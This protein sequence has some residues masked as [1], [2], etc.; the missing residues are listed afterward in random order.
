MHRF[1][2]V[3]IIP[4]VLITVL[5]TGCQKSGESKGQGF[6]AENS[7]SVN[8]STEGSF[9]IGPGS[10]EGFCQFRGPDEGAPIFEAPC[11]P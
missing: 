10:S 2:S 11:D 4:A 9:L 7:T 5:L 6:T 8:G 1:A 3:V